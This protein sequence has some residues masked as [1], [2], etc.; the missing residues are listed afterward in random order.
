MKQLINCMACCLLC[1]PAVGQTIDRI[2]ILGCIRQDRPL[3]ALKHYCDLNA[4]LHLWIGDNIYADTDDPAV[5]RKCY[6]ELSTKPNFD[7]LL[8]RGQHM[9]TWDDHD[10]GDNNVGKDY[11]L[12]A[13]SK[14]LFVE[15]WGLQNEIPDD[16]QG[17]WYSR[18]FR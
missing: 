10:Y 3:P 12:K 1:A 7:R 5:I 15:F 4:D 14:R 8:R 18:N 16:Q 9:F 17:I 11:P 2:A 6:E 13:A